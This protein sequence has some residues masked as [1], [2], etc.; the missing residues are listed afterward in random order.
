MVIHFLLAETGLI[1]HSGLRIA[2]DGDRIFLKGKGRVR[3]P[4][5]QSCCIWQAHKNL[6]LIVI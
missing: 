5:E 4:R 1:V 2:L 3:S 6:H